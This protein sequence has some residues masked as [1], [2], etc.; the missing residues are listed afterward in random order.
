MKRNRILYG[1]LFLGVFFAAIL[2]GDPLM[3]MTL[4]ALIA[5]P[6][7]SA[8]FALIT[9]YGLS[10]TQK[11]E[12][13]TVVK[14]EQNRYFITLH[15]K[16]KIGFGTLRCIFLEGHFAVETTADRVRANVKPFMPPLRFPMSFTIKYRGTYQIGLS[17]LE[18]I[19]FL[20]LFN[21]R[22]KLSATFEVVA[23]PRI[24]DLENMHLAIHMLSKAPANL[25][26]LQE[27]YADFTDV[28]PYVPSDP[29]KKIHWKLTAKRGE[30]MVKNYQTSALNSMAIIVDS[31]KRKLPSEVV[32]KLE[33]NIIESTVAVLLYCLRQQMPVDLLFGYNIREKGRHIGDFNNMY[34]TIASLHFEDENFSLYNAVSSY[35]NETSRNVNVVILTSILT[36]PLYEQILNAMRFGHYI[37]VIYFIPDGVASSRDSDEVFGRLTSSGISCLKL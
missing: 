10:I 15:N 33:D 35:L 13:D 36:M 11:T 19:D 25:S 14:G 30:W 1:G 29:V 3:F 26:I 12:Q 9:L 21:I 2:Y 28:R 37:A 27:D 7:F 22:R 5:M 31:T 32:I 6:V 23:Y 17:S 18:I 24:T 16:I 20:G 8:L 34:N 4:Y